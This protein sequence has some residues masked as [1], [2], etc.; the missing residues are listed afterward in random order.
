MSVSRRGFIAASL[1]SGVLFSPQRVRAAEFTLKMAT[2]QPLTHPLNVRTNEMIQKITAETNGRVQ[3]NLFPN[4]QLGGDTDMVSQLRTGAIDIFPTSGN[5]L[6]V[7]APEVSIYNVAFAWKDDDQVW[8]AMDG[9]LGAYLRKS[10]EPA[11]IIAFEKMV[12]WGFR[13]ITSTRAINSPEDLNGM[14]IRVAVSPIMT[15]LFKHLGAAPTTINIK[16]T[17]S[18]LQTHLVDA[19]ENPLSI[20]DSWKF[21]EVQKY[22]A[23]T[24]HVWDGLWVLANA[25]SWNRL[26]ANLRPILSRNINDMAVN[27]RKDIRHLNETLRTKLQS[28]GMTFTT[29][30][31][32]PF[33]A[34]LRTSGYYDDWRSKYGPPAWAV[35][36]KYAGKLT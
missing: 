11:G 14:K 3:I 33:R 8:A 6:E 17:Y 25:N 22:C 35:L 36:E 9:G 19:Q 1:A 15:S 31:V 16:E 7:F 10:L 20:I 2:N 32:A 28:Q 4:G 24:N 18:A 34:L 21:Y 27:A 13:E 29:P 5:V 23:L 26:P 12:G 30:N